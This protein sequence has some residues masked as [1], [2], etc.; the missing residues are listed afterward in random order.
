MS[1]CQGVSGA[2]KSVL[3]TCTL[4]GLGSVILFNV[5]V[6]SPSGYVERA[7]FSF[8]I[9]YSRSLQDA[10]NAP[11]IISSGLE[12]CRSRAGSVWRIGLNSNGQGN[13][14]V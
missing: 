6:I 12:H 10:F 3:V 5:E 7:T 4:P 14:S 13:R 1:A 2:F 9:C 8:R 11:S